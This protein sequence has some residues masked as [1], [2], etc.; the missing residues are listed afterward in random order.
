MNH[1]VKNKQGFTVIE[2]MLAMSFIAILLL[3]IAMTVIQIGTIYNKGLALKEVNQMSRDLATDFRKSLSSVE[4]I[5]LASD[6]VTNSAGGRVCMGTVSYLWNTGKALKNN[7]TNLTWYGNDAAHTKTV[8]FVKVSD[9]SRIYCAKTG[10]GAL[11]YRDIRAADASQAQELMMEGDHNLNIN[12]FVLTTSPSAYDSTTLQQLYT[13]D[14]IIG[15]GDISAM[16]ANQSG[17]LNAGTAGSDLSYCNVQE[18]SLVIRAGNR[19]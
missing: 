6:Y 19:V 18:F 1:V 17:C 2:L 8:R 9:I 5:T 7:D 12:K 16:N 10:T 4:A 11:V 13:L 14:Y 15:S 3:A